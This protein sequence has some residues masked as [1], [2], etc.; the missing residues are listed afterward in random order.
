[1]RP[2]RTVFVADN[3]I[4]S[5]RFVVFK[6]NGVFAARRFLLATRCSP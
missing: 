2:I 3:R 6:V 1:M 5:V 4:L